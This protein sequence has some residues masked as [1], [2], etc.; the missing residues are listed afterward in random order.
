MKPEEKQRHRKRKGKRICI[1]G[2]EMICTKGNWICKG[3]MKDTEDAL[4]KER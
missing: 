1:C 2:S 3:Q 4:N